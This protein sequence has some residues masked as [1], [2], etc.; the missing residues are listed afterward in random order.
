MKLCHHIS[1]NIFIIFSLRLIFSLGNKKRLHRPRSREYGGYCS[2]FSQ[3]PLLKKL[4]ISTGLL[5]QQTR[6]L[7]IRWLHELP[8]CFS[9]KLKIK[10]F[11]FQYFLIPAHTCILFHTHQN[12]YIFVWTPPYYIIKT[13]NKTNKSQYFLITTRMCILLCV[14]IY[15]Y[16]YIYIS[17]THTPEDEYIIP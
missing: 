14:C 12:S 8:N 5:G 3:K 13:K 7:N 4:R 11:Q 17:H 1:W 2:V 9:F 6:F 16:I 10:T 15:I